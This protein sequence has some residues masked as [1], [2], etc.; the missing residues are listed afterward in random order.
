[1]R[2]TSFNLTDSTVDY[3][4]RSKLSEH[5]D[6]K[7]SKRKALRNFRWFS[8]IASTNH[9]LNYVVNSYTTS[10]LSPTLGVITLG[11]NWTLNAVSG[12]LIASPIVKRLG[13]KR[14]IIISFWGYTLQIGTLFLAA[15]ITDTTV[16]WTVS[17]L[18]AVLAGLTSAIWWTAQGVCFELSCVQIMKSS[19]ESTL[20]VNLLTNELDDLNRIRSD[21]SAEWTLIYQGMDIIVFLIVG[22]VPLLDGISTE[23][24]IAALAGL[25]ALTSILGETFDSNGDEGGGE[26][27][28]SELGCAVMLVPKQVLLLL[29]L[30]LDF[31]ISAC[32]LV[33]RR[34]FFMYVYS[35]ALTSDRHCLLRLSLVSDFLLRCSTR[36]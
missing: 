1:M 32:Q 11:L 30:V 17:I 33:I 5:A 3:R 36:S 18:G 2:S 9:A 21:L 29:M 20:K 22:L 6:T 27:T 26:F 31:V 34:T 24:V 10:V 23:I 35:L 15:V 4:M 25:G 28:W 13:F 19:D 8:V 12:L 14:A 7:S 16:A